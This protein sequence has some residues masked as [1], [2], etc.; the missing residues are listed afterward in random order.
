MET[1]KNIN[2][3]KSNVGASKA[4]G[5]RKQSG[6]GA[7]PITSHQGAPQGDAQVHTDRV[8][9]GGTQPQGGTETHGA[10]GDKP[11]GEQDL[12]QQAKQTTGEIVNQVQQRAGS[13]L[14]RQKESAGSDLS[15]VV[16]AVRRFGESLAGE[17][18]G[19]IARYA[20][21]YGDKAAN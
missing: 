20:A 15:T 11:G 1:Q 5:G 13:Q 21:Q 6:G 4:G 14:T 19:P 3:P 17:E 9:E 7:K 18:N 8:A 10:T 16:D 12:L 2:E